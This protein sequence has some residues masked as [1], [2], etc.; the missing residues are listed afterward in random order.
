MGSRVYLH[1]VLLAFVQR[2]GSGEAPTVLTGV[3][4]AKHDLLVVAVNIPAIHASP[5][6]GLTSSQ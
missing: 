1:K 3:A 5:S 6:Q 4:V 2:P